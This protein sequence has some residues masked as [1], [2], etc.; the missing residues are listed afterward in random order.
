MLN[1]CE[2]CYKNVETT[3]SVIEGIICSECQTKI[4]AARVEPKRNCLIDGT[5]MQKDLV[6]NIIID[7]CPSCGGVWLDGGEIDVMKESL[8]NFQKAKNWVNKIGE[9]LVYGFPSVS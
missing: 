4:Q 6:F 9:A 7:K 2:R 1:E 5:E 8:K 3:T